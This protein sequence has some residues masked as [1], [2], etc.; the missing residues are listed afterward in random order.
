MLFVHE[1]L[2]YRDG[3]VRDN[4][5]WEYD[6]TTEMV[7]NRNGGRHSY[8][9][10]SQEEIIESTWEEILA[11]TLRN[12]DCI[13]GWI[14]PDGE[15]FGC[16][17]MDHVK[18]AK[19]YLKTEEEQLE[20]DGWIKITEVPWWARSADDLNGRYEYFFFNPY[21]HITQSQYKTLQDKGL[22]LKEY[23]LKYNL[24]TEG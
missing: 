3:V 24:A 17:P 2:T 13:T 22:K 5:W 10:T 14:A 21:K 20:S 1:F 6:P 18:L 16:D 23:D 4:G 11:K 19:Y 15:F 8:T 7:Y 12:D 9:H